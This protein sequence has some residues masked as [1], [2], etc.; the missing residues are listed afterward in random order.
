MGIA[1]ARGMRAMLLGIA[2]AAWAFSA[3]AAD[4]RAPQ[5]QGAGRF[6]VVHPYSSGGH[7]V[8]LDTSNGNTWRLAVA[9]GD[10]SKPLEPGNML[11][12]WLPLSVSQ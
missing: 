5:P 9:P 3:L 10:P 6:Q 1:Y 7:T 2:A 11:W 4:P 12:F 8:L